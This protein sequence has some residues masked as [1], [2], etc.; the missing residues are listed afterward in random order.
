VSVSFGLALDA[1]R[2]SAAIERLARGPM[3]RAGFVLA[4]LVG[5]SAALS[6]D[7]IQSLTGGY[8]EYR[9]LGMLVLCLIVGLGFAVLFGADREA[10]TGAL[11]VMGRALSVAVLI[12]GAFG[13]ARVLGLGSSVAGEGLAGA[14][15]FAS[16]LGNASNL[17][18]YL[19]LAL[20]LVVSSGL[21]ET[22]AWRIVGWAASLAGVAMILATQSRGAWAGGLAAL[23]AGTVLAS[24][25]LPRRRVVVL[26]G[27][28]AGSVL[29]VAILA[30]ALVPGV[31]SRAASALDLDRGTVRW[32]AS[33]WSSAVR[34]ARDRPLVGSGPA[35]FRLVFP[36]YREPGLPDPGLSGRSVDD[37][38]DLLLDTAAVSGIPAAA[39]LL[40]VLGSGAL[41]A[42]RSAAPG[43]G[44]RDAARALGASLVGG[45]VA[46]S[47]HFWTADTGPLFVSVLVGLALMEAA[48]PG[49]SG[50]GS[51]PATGRSAAGKVVVGIAGLGVIVSAV[52]AVL[53]GQVAVGDREVAAGFG[54]ADG[55]RPWTDVRA[56]ALGAQ[57]A[58]PWEA[59]FDWAGG[60]MA[61]IA[62]LER[63]E[64]AA[65]EDGRVWMARARARLLLDARVA[66]QQGDL[67]LAAAGGSGLKEHLDAASRFYREAHDMD[68]M[69]PVP[70]VGLGDA[71]AAQGDRLGAR[72]AYAAA[73]QASPRFEPAWAGLAQV[74][75]AMGRPEEARSAEATAKRLRM[76]RPADT[77]S[78]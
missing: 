77:T 63:F 48:A 61:T 26:F 46:L 74:Y 51:P 22:R 70:L 58:A 60:R 41:A 7:W 15:R 57:G 28:T 16:T 67:L 39:V 13:A 53:A 31:A 37:A 19:V 1:G 6:V 55:G 65:L 43:S 42:W 10:G 66:A 52:V 24:R 72:D 49:R 68:P 8:S 78:P 76:G 34:M 18:V 32:R 23:A 14:D 71:L 38:H 73:I 50:A 59:A 20:P 54:A 33:V 44:Q 36:A 21:R 35:T 47:F 64:E 40:L 62:L 45:S 56:R 17:G 2:A 69:N 27:A 11:P 3:G 30:G 25:G 75:A 12:V 29:A 4:A 5:A 9:G